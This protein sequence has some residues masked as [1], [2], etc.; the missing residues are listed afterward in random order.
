MLTNGDLNFE[1]MI[2]RYG[3][4]MAYH[5]L[6]QIERAAGIS[7]SSMVGV[8]LELRLANACRVQD[9]RIEVD[10]IAEK[11]LAA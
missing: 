3:D 5:Y 1:D 8:S 2:V 7:P 4:I 9:G 11:D 6:E 10:V